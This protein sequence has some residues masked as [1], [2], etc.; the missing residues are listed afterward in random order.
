MLYCAPS[1]RQSNDR[2]R[3]TG[4]NFQQSKSELKTCYLSKRSTT[5]LQ[6]KF[7]TIKQKSGEN[8][9]QDGLRVDNI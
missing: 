9:R 8:A 6:I 4:Y 7:N 1:K 2:F 3:D 5:H